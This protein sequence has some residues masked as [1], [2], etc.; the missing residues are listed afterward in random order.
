[1]KVNDGQMTS[2]PGPIPIAA[3]ARWSPVVHEV[4]AIPCFAPT[5]DATAFSNS[6]TFGPWVTQPLLIDSN[7]ARASSSVSDG[8][9]MGTFSFF[10]GA[11]AMRLTPRARGRERFLPPFDEP[12][13][14]ILETGLRAEAEDLLRARRV[15]DPPCR[16]RALGLGPEFDPNVLPGEPEEQLRELPERGLHAAAD[17]HDSVRHGRV[18]G[19]D[20]RPRDVRDVHV[21]GRR[22]AV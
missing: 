15:T 21:V 2:S 1:M 3:S 16:K 17:V 19:E 9:V 18:A 12:R 10:C 11:M 13:D 5:Y 22:G 7:G 20:V 14:A 4:V 8:F 6:A